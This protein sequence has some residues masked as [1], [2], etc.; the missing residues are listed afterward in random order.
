MLSARRI[1]KRFGRTTV[2]RELD[3]N[4]QPGQLHVRFGKNGAGKSTLLRI[5]ATL[6]RPTSGELTYNGRSLAKHCNAIRSE[7]GFAGHETFIYSDLTVRE[8]L[9]F[10]HQLYEQSQS[11]DEILSWS[12]LELRQNTP[13][14]NL[15]RGIQQR[16]AIARALLHRPKLLLL[17]EPFTGLDLQSADRLSKL[18]THSRT[19]GVTVLFTTHDVS[20]GVQ[21]ADRSLILGSGRIVFEGEKITADVIENELLGTNEPQ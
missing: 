10:Y 15:S 5:A 4:L 8:N 19:Q 21:L 9:E 17:D 12:F 6:L 3:F 18:L 13:V 1:T 16:V 7:I 14:R 11:V 20:L 2:L